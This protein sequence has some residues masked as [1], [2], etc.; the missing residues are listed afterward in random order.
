MWIL[1]AQNASN[2]AASLSHPAE[3]Q[4]EKDNV[5]HYRDKIASRKI[6]G[7][8]K[9]SPSTDPT[10]LEYHLSNPFSEEARKL[11]GLWFPGTFS[12]QG[13]PLPVQSPS[14]TLLSTIFLPGLGKGYRALLIL[15]YW[16][17][18]QRNG[19]DRTRGILDTA[20]PP[21]GP[22]PSQPQSLLTLSPPLPA[23]DHKHASPS[24][25][26]KIILLKCDAWPLTCQP[27]RPPSHQGPTAA[28][29]RKPWASITR[30]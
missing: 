13:A 9:L 7:E 21:D 3:N 24:L 14:E 25:R 28:P 11:G 17:G 29:T 4:S 1:R 2:T 19:A 12:Y 5:K 30:L 10:Q 20:C 6:P 23:E 27:P 15:K 8:Y 18:Q 22:S 16:Q 26:T